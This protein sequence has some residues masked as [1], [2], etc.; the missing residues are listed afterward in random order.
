[1]RDKVFGDRPSPFGKNTRRAS[2]R[3]TTKRLG[4]MMDSHY[5][6]SIS[7]GT[8]SVLCHGSGQSR[9]VAAKR[10][11]GRENRILRE[12][13]PA[14]LR[15]YETT[16]VRTICCCS[17][18]A[19]AKASGRGAIRCRDRLSGPCGS[20]KMHLELRPKFPSQ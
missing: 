8:H 15:L 10:I 3:T 18:F 5:A 1:L 9:I 12:H 16:K 4:H 2:E 7:L 14:R 17:R 13:L 19:V 6:R 11:L 20:P